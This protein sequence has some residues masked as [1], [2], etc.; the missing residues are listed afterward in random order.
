MSG[1]RTSN[2]SRA[3]REPRHRHGTARRTLAFGCRIRLGLCLGPG[4]RIFELGRLRP[5]ASGIGHVARPAGVPGS[6]SPSPNGAPASRTMPTS[7]DATSGASDGTW[8]VAMI[9]STRRHARP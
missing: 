5:W 9:S 2:G 7:P 3:S 6:A 4:R 1:R 8:C